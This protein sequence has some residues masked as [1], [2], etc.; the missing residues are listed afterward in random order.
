MGIALFPK[1]G[2]TVEDL[3][4]NADM[5]LYSTKY[6]GKDGYTYYEPAMSDDMQYKSEQEKHLR[7]A[8]YNQEFMLHYQPLIDVRQKSII[9]HEALIR[10]NSS[11]YGMVMPNQIIP[12]AEE[13]GFIDK[14]GKWVIDT[15]FAFAKRVEPLNLCTS[16]NVSPV[17]LAQ[18]NFVED[19]LKSFEH[20]DLKKGSVAIEITESCLIESFDEVMWKLSLLR[21]KGIL[22]YLDDFG[23]GYSS[24]NYLKNLPVD[25]IKIDKSFIAEITKPGVDSKILKTIVTL[26]HELGIRTVAEGVETAEQLEL[27]EFYGCD[28]AQGYLISRPKPEEEIVND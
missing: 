28:M 9:G 25:Y 3:F 2:S 4:K 14:I 12:L 17:Q 5:V 8:Y 6:K 26:A 10:W 21:E 22:I 24:L 23:T 11:R 1:D 20:H 13:I 15:A 27:L 18:N 7:Q 16:C 19:V